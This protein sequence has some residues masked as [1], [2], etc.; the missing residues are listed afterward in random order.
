MGLSVAVASLADK[1]VAILATALDDDFE[2]VRVVLAEK[3]HAAV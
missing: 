3:V 2:I 1:V